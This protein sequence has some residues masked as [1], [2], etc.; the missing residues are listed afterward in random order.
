MQHFRLSLFETITISVGG[1]RGSHKFAKENREMTAFP[2]STF[3]GNGYHGMIRGNQHLPC[4][5]NMVPID[6][7]EDAAI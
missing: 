7:F 3:F 1:R 6:F 4:S 2:E 5:F